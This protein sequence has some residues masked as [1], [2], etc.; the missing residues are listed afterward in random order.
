MFRYFNPNPYGKNVGDCVIRAICKAT[1]KDWESVYLDICVQG[2]FEGDMPSANYVWGKWLF[3]NG[4]KKYWVEGYTVKEFAKENPEGTF[5]LMVG[6]H[7]VCLQ[8]GNW[9]DT[10]DSGNE[11]IFFFYRKEC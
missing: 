6:E 9:Y 5:V 1:N 8:N 10:F 2:L 11:T 3:K 4:F 7:A